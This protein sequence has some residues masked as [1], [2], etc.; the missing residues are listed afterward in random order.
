M[1]PF[2]DVLAEVLP[3]GFATSS[4]DAAD[5]GGDGALGLDFEKPDLAGVADVGAAAEFL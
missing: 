3:G 2:L 4:L 1:V 5:T